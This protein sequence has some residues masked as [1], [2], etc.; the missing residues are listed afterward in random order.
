MTKGLK[1]NTQKPSS[2]FPSGFERR[3]A[4][5]NVSDRLFR[6]ASTLNTLEELRLDRQVQQLRYNIHVREAQYIS[7]QER[8]KRNLKEQDLYKKALVRTV[9]SQDVPPQYGRYNGRCFESLAQERDMI[10]KEIE[11]KRKRKTEK[12]LAKSR[13]ESES[14]IDRSFSTE[15]L[16]RNSNKPLSQRFNQAPFSK[17]LENVQTRTK[18]LSMFN[19]LHNIV[20]E[21]NEIR[22]LPS[23]V[24]KKSKGM[25][26]TSTDF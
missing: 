23:T 12:L 17:K 6:R 26:Q 7:V 14:L 10:L 11:R 16:L 21:R 9:A 5:Q 22:R 3:L 13:L 18:A 19:K 8:L 2:D 25:F 20:K 15:Y 1:Q 24:K 4:L